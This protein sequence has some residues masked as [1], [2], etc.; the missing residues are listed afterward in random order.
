MQEAEREAARQVTRAG[1]FS[2]GIPG[3]AARGRHERDRLDALIRRSGGIVA[4]MRGCERR[5]TL[6]LTD[7]VNCGIVLRDKHH[8]G[9]PG[10]A[11]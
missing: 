7:D 2:R 4:Y 6:V 8:P 9:P 5:N 11:V 1:Q 10:S 3:T